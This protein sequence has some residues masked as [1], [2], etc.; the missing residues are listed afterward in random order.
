MARFWPFEVWQAKQAEAWLE[1]MA[2][3][4]WR[5]AFIGMLAAHFVKREPAQVRYKCAGRSNFESF[6]EEEKLKEKYKLAGW[7]YID[8]TWR[9]LVFCDDGNADTEEVP[10]DPVRHAK[11]VK[12]TIVNQCFWFVAFLVAAVYFIYSQISN[13]WD[14]IT[15]LLHKNISLLAAAGFAGLSAY[16]FIRKVI[17]LRAEHFR[18][19]GDNPSG[20][21]RTDRLNRFAGKAK[22]TLLILAII[23][24]GFWAVP[25][26]IRFL[27]PPAKPVALGLSDVVDFS[28]PQTTDETV[29]DDYSNGDFSLLFPEQH[30]SIQ[31]PIKCL[32]V[33]AL[34]PGLAQ[35]LAEQTAVVLFFDTE[36][37]GDEAYGFDRFWSY[38]SSN[39]NSILAV[40]GCDFYHIDFFGS[41]SSD[42]LAKALLNKINKESK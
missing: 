26:Y 33:H 2:E 40:K 23:A 7:R 31:G 21:M 17:W 24:I 20:E 19:Y 9:L 39:L 6:E 11:I 13:P 15:S 27:P 34:F 38:S 22:A 12:R 14:F 32:S 29:T 1:G 41:I 18:I 30:I 16:H 35:L 5:L 8:N 36:Q 25:S 3:Q 10:V 4:G 28:I 42:E 37:K